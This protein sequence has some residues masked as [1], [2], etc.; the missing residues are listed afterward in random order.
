MTSVEA[1]YMLSLRTPPSLSDHIAYRIAQ[2]ISDHKSQEPTSRALPTLPTVPLQQVQVQVA[3]TSCAH[4]P[5]CILLMG[6]E[7]A[8]LTY[9]L[10]LSKQFTSYRAN[11]PRLTAAV[12]TTLTH[13]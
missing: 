3:E 4:T 6:T 7:Q 11:D 9:L 5:R 10:P 2:L 1:K 12:E 8:W 13:V